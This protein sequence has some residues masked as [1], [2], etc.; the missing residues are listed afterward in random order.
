MPLACLKLSSGRVGSARKCYS[1]DVPTCKQEA[2][3]R[4]WSKLLCSAV[5]SPFLSHL[6]PPLPRADLCDSGLLLAALLGE[7]ESGL[8]PGVCYHLFPNPSACSL[9]VSE[10]T[11]SEEHLIYSAPLPKLGNFSAAG[12]PHL[13]TS[14]NAM[15]LVANFP[16]SVTAYLD[17]QTHSARLCVGLV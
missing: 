14:C 10:A 7:L 8:L 13:H 16:K 15:L 5:V 4:D 3:M 11:V 9:S 17:M 2:K 6:M 12:F 1:S